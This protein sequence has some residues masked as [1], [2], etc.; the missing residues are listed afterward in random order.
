MNK[1]TGF[2]KGDEGYLVV[3]KKE[4]KCIWMTAGFISYKLC[5]YEFQCDRCPLYWELRNES[6][7]S[8]LERRIKD[9]RVEFN[10]SLIKEEDWSNKEDLFSLKE[11]L[12]YHTGHTWIKIE[13][14][15]EVRIGI[16]HFLSKL[17]RRVNVIVLPLP[18]RRK[19]RGE[20]LC[21]II[22]EGGILN[23]IS[24]LTGI[25]LSVNQKLK[26]SPNLIFK[27]PLGDGYLLTLKPKD[28]QKDQ[29]NLLYGEKAFLWYKKEWER[30]KE[31]LFVEILQD[32]GQ[33]RL[34]ITM[35]DGVF[36]IKDIKKIIES[37][38][39]TLLINNFLRKGEEG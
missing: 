16:D 36:N 20:N 5:K 22:Q 35:Q 33:Y 19:K 10:T 25:I 21:S 2:Q 34:G 29:K 24:P 7:D 11:S 39:Y 12:F 37:S 14:A 30:L 27:D 31:T 1:K 8:L 23:I 32:H 3:P 38:K 17:L 18:K 26:E 15:D 13:S 9:E 28:L 4:L 6:V